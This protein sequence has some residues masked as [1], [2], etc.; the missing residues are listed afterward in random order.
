M[1]R[2]RVAPLNNIKSIKIVK[3]HASKR[4]PLGSGSPPIFVV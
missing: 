1:W 2:V 3:Q 4:K